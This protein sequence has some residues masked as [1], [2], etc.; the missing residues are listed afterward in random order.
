MADLLWGLVW[1][2][3]ETLAQNP[4]LGS[5]SLQRETPDSDIICAPLTKKGSRVGAAR[6]PSVPAPGIGPPIVSAQQMLR[7]HFAAIRI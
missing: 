5:P 3:Q 2:L 4:I 7:G 1:I 6:G